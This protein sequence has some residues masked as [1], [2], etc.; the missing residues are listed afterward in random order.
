SNTAMFN[1][2]SFLEWFAIVGTYCANFGLSKAS[3]RYFGTQTRGDFFFD[4]KRE[5]T[6]FAE[7]FSSDTPKFDVVLG[8]PNTG[9]TALVREVVEKGNFTPLFIDCRQGQ[10]DTPIN[11]YQSISQL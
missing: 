6:T 3:V 1:S 10:F 4:R 11:A 9:K 5:R 8:P 7:V 2:T